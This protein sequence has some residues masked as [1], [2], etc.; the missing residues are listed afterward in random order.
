MVDFFFKGLFFQAV[1]TY[2]CPILDILIIIAISRVAILLKKL[3]KA[4]GD[5]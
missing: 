3:I 1:E 2:A 4:L 5:K